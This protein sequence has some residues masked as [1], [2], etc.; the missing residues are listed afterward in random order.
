MRLNA[1]L[2]PANEGRLQGVEPAVVG[3]FGCSAP[4]VA[5]KAR[6]PGAPVVLSVLKRIE[7]PVERL[8]HQV[9]RVSSMP[10][11]RQRAAESGVTVPPHQLLGCGPYGG[12]GQEPAELGVG[13]GDDDC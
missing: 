6:D 3:P 11:Q 10:A 8:D 9:L 4:Y 1:P 12:D 7:S 13:K 5:E 2:Q